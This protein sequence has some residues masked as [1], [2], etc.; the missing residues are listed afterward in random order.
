M[1]C[2]MWSVNVI[3]SWSIWSIHMSQ[4][5]TICMCCGALQKETAISMQID[6]NSTTHMWFDCGNNQFRC[7][8]TIWY[9]KWL[10]FVQ[11][12]RTESAGSQVHI[13]NQYKKWSSSV[14]AVITAVVKCECTFV[15]LVFL[16]RSDWFLVLFP[17]LWELLLLSHHFPLQCSDCCYSSV[18]FIVS[19]AV[20]VLSVSSPSLLK[21]D[22]IVFCYFF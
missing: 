11:C 12:V 2:G 10:V 21:M 4:F 18:S 16:H 17:F 15:C 13:Q 8:C 5:A 9:K 14:C 19:F 7:T 6:A 20:S 1:Q 22:L 3:E